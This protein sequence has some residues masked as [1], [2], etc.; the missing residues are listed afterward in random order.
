MW[1]LRTSLRKCFSEC[2]KR[3]LKEEL[4]VLHTNIMQW[5]IR[6]YKSKREREQG[7]EQGDWWRVE[8][9]R[10]RDGWQGMRAPNTPIVVE[11]CKR[12]SP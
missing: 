4:A 3:I 7:E 2:Y 5:T 1:F 10:V 6:E 9:P 12:V 11:L 8:C